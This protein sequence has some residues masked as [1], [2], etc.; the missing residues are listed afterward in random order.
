M[1]LAAIDRLVHYA[2]ILEMN[3]ESYRRRAALDCKR[4]SGRPPAHATIRLSLR[5]NQKRQSRKML[6]NGA[7]QADHDP[8][9]GRHFKLRL[10][11]PFSSRLSRDSRRQHT[12]AGRAK[13]LS[14]R[15]LGRSTQ[16]KNAWKP[17]RKRW[18]ER[19]SLE[20]TRAR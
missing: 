7:T 4:G 8:A 12:Q 1:T 9:T 20:G 16:A 6:A 11:L 17:S 18:C 14:F 15:W 5:D 13:I 10:S 19:P 3:V 2:A